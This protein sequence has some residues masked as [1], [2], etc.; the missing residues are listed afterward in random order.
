[1]NGQSAELCGADRLY[2]VYE[3][4]LLYPLP[5]DLLSASAL[6]CRDGTEKRHI[7][8]CFVSNLCRLLCLNA[9]PYADYDLWNYDD[10]ILCAL[11]HRCEYLGIS[12]RSKNIQTQDIRLWLNCYRQS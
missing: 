2:P 9:A 8:Y 3:P 4:V 1:M 12:F 5:Y 11:Q 7:P 10:C 6:Q